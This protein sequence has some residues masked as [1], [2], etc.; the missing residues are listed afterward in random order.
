MPR[1]RKTKK[2]KLSPKK[3]QQPP[4]EEVVEPL[5]EATPG[6]RNKRI[7][8]IAFNPSRRNL[9]KKTNLNLKLNFDVSASSNLIKPSIA[10]SMPSGRRSERAKTRNMATKSTVTRGAV[11]RRTFKV[12]SSPRVIYKPPKMSIFTDFPLMVCSSFGMIFASTLIAMASILLA[13]DYST[14]FNTESK[15]IWKLKFSGLLPV[16]YLHS[17]GHFAILQLLRPAL[18]L[19][20][21]KDLYYCG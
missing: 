4:V 20:Q 19:R 6:R 10:E 16:L 3:E 12:F 18:H 1:T 13:V 8:S 5:P 14:F 11:V 2:T 21:Y 15:N 9:K 17:G 7:N